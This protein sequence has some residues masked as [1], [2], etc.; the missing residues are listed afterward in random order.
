MARSFNRSLLILMII[1]MVNMFR[2][3]IVS[4]ILSLYARKQGLT[5]EELGILSTAGLLGW[6]I[7]EPILGLV[8]D[9]VKKRYLLTIAII[10]STG[11]YLLYPYA[12]SL[13]HF[14]VLSF[15][16]NSVMS[17][18]S[19]SV[20]SLVAELLP[21]ENR[22]KTYGQFA[23][24]VSVSG[25]IAPFIGGFVSDVYGYTIP[26]YIAACIGTINIFIVWMLKEANSVSKS[27]GSLTA[28]WRSFLGVD[29]LSIFAVRGLYFINFTFRSSFLPIIL[30]E[31]P[32]IRA[33]ASEIGAYLSIVGF[34]TS[35][36]Q[37]LIG[38]ISDR[39]GNRKTIIVCLSLLSISY[40]LLIESQGI[41]LI[42]L[43]GGLQGILQAGSEVAM[44]M[45][46]ISVIPKN[47]TGLAMGL[48]SEAEN[49]GG[50][51]ASPIMGI[52]YASYGA[53][54]LLIFHVSI[55]AGTSL[56]SI[57]TI[58]SI[59]KNEDNLKIIKKP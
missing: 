53:T 6:F 27:S 19:I 23:S 40:L 7:F 49:I 41:L 52:I 25:V 57:I 4:P 35:A 11:V 48:Y 36:S 34:A 50:V 14:S 24:I 13:L 51:I 17:C 38:G 54:A 26:F 59:K 16:M 37:A 22:G 29:I 12:S 31:S 9:R 30:N 10:G 20:K 42:Y 56:L 8:V 28:G 18:Y 47:M 15:T 43:I 44:M 32:R 39:F 33:S 45:Q 1:Q 5:I 46:L 21:V 2:G 55:I 3:G 58:R